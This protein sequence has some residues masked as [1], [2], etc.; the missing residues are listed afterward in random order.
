MSRLGATCKLWRRDKASRSRRPRWFVLCGLPIVVLFML[1][2][3]LGSQVITEFPVP[4]GTGPEGITAGPDGALWFA[5]AGANAIGRITTSGTVTLFPISGEPN[6]IT[7]GLDGNLWFTLSSSNFVGRMTPDG[8]ATLFGLPAGSLQP[9]GITR[10]PDGALWFA[11]ASNQI[12]RITTSGVI[13]IFPILTGGGEPVGIT[14]GLDGALWFT[15]Q[16]RFRIG[17]AATSGQI[18]DFQLAGTA[19]PNGITSGP[20]GALWFTRV[21]PDAIG[22]TTLSGQITEFA[23][24]NGSPQGIATGP[25]GNLWFVASAST[26]YVGRMTPT[27]NLSMFVVPTSG[28][29]LADIVVGPDG[30]MWFTELAD[31]IGR[32]SVPVTAAIPA[33]SRPALVVLGLALIVTAM[34]LIR[35]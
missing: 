18:S 10:G 20:D 6:F 33:A 14:A 7:T 28:T 35:R 8:T 11:V 2:S 31:K 1:R 22:R 13:T 23:I 4:P 15:E 3:P 27:G 21:F 34:L 9:R 12:G 25:D 5:A 24:P 17:R 19:V 32:I 29:L 30:A 16:F 26:G